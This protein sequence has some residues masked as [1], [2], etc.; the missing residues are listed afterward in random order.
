MEASATYEYVVQQKGKKVLIKKAV[1]ITLYF[2][3]V[4]G[5][6]VLGTI[7]KLILPCLAFVP[8]TLWII[9]FFTWKHTNIEFEYSMTAGEITVS[10]I[11]G[12]RSRKTVTRLR[13]KDC[14]LIAP[15]NEENRDRLVRFGAEKSFS[16]LSSPDAE[17]AYFAIYKDGDK[18]C[19]FYF[20]ATDRALKICKFY[21][22]HATVT[23]HVSR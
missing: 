19:V 5:L 1:F 18:K 17:D 21:N 2:A 4:I 14:E 11:Y 13:I 8:L 16:A 23:G 9:A 12:G 20:E 3:Y 10:N 6:F 7:I 22:S 15:L